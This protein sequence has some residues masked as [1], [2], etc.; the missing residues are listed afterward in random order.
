LQ[1]DQRTWAAHSSLAAIVTESAA[2]G[3]LDRRDVDF[4]HLHHRLE[5]AL[6]CGAIGIGD[7]Y[8]ERAA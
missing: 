7:C 3:R 1:R 4:S 5:S 6:G 8:S 2:P